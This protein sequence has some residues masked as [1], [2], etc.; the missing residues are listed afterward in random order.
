MFSVVCVSV[1]KG[2]HMTIA[3]DVLG[4]TIQDPHFLA[5]WTGTPQ[6]WPCSVQGPSSPSHAPLL[7]TSGAQDQRLIQSCSLE[8]PLLLVTS[9]GQ[10]CG[11]IQTHSLEDSLVLTSGGWLLKHVWF[12]LEQA[13][14]TCF[15]QH[16]LL[17]LTGPQYLTINIFIISPHLLD[18][19]SQKQNPL[20]D[21][22]GGIMCHS[23]AELDWYP[24]S[25]FQ[26]H[27]HITP[28]LYHQSDPF[29]WPMVISSKSYVSSASWVLSNITTPV[30]QAEIWK[31]RHNQ[32]IYCNPHLEMLWRVLR[33]VSLQFTCFHYLLQYFGS[34]RSLGNYFVWCSNISVL[35]LN[36]YKE[37]FPPK[38]M[39]TRV[40][41]KLL[42]TISMQ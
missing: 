28:L 40:A 35:S 42:S 5:P 16:T 13:V 20:S 7:V 4:L 26:S 1:H 6:P 29:V 30:L 34:S 23:C 41:T 12:K 24:I 10:D 3:H 15:A 19:D 31:A 25:T 33:V 9:S 38:G 14:H 37:R 17:Q 27:A 21:S 18:C 22:L 32:F 2:S 11:P 39:T 36:I 8:E